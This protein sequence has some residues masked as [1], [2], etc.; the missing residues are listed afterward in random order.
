MLFRPTTAAWPAL[1]LGSLLA[2]AVHGE[3]GESPVVLAQSLFEEG[4]RLM[5]A[6]DYEAACPKLA[7]SQRLDPGGG[8]LLNLARCHEL[9]G[10]VATAWA[11]Y[12][13]ALGVARA[14]ERADRVAEAEKRIAELE[15]RLSY[16]VIEVADDARIDGLEIARNGQPVPRAAW[17]SRIPT[18]PGAVEI[19][20]T[21]R[22]H[23]QVVIRVTVG[24]DG[25]VAVARVPRLTPI[26]TPS[27]KPMPAA[28]PEPAPVGPARPAPVEERGDTTVPGLVALGVGGAALGVGAYFGV[29]ALS[30]RADSDD[31]CDRSEC[32]GADG[33]RAVELNDEAMKL[34]WV[35]NGAIALGLISAGLGVYWIA[36]S[37]GD[38]TAS[39]RVTLTA[40]PS[41][42]GVSWRHRW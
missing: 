28:A 41:G 21:A 4:R 3:P 1:A 22:A 16:L 20:A 15:G 6:G 17:G 39:G 40:T 14:D 33:K 26:E 36:S 8:T 11:E 38:T 12:K 24:T 10:R 30:K 13:E 34:A 2:P 32:S 9:Q 35:S 37:P 27:D 23:R 31:L 5:D 25:N 18:D 29:R 19:V 7:E 42:A